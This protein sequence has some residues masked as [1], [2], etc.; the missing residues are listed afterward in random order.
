[1]KKYLFICLSLATLFNH[2][3]PNKKQL[4]AIRRAIQSNA[5]EA[6]ARLMA[7]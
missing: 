3:K 2:G 1:M 4:D 7:A 6:E 5:K